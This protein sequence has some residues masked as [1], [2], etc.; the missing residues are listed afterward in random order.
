MNVFNCSTR[1]ARRV[2]QA[3]DRCAGSERKMDDSLTS[4]NV[5]IV[6]ASDLLAETSNGAAD[7]RLSASFGVIS[8]IF[9][10]WGST[11]VSASLSN[12]QILEI[13]T[14]AVGEY[15]NLC[16]FTCFY[17]NDRRLKCLF[18]F[19]KAQL[20]VGLVTYYLSCIIFCPPC[21]VSSGSNEVFTK[22]RK[23]SALKTN[24]L[25]NEQCSF[26]DKI[27]SFSNNSTLSWQNTD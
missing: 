11:F 2:W 13:L 19:T 10:C 15:S 3:G 26:L 14:W 21:E 18:Y 17:V 20:N 4:W 9:D 27:V 23:T 12:C 6:L 24:I 5:M 22:G 16:S 8:L 1:E 7:F 25:F